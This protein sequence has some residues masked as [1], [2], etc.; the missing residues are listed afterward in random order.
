[1][2]KIAI[3]GPESTGK[4]TLAEKLAKHFNTDFMAG[5]ASG[6]YFCSRQKL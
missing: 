6:G 2:F 5:F 4:S 1:M 3:T